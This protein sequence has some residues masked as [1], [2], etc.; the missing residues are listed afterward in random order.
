[1]INPKAQAE[2]IPAHVV[3]LPYMWIIKITNAVVLVEANQEFAI[4]DRNVSWHQRSPREFS[5]ASERRKS[6]LF[7]ILPQLKVKRMGDENGAR[8][9]KDVA[10]DQKPRMLALTRE[11]CR[12]YWLRTA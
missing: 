9:W 8:G 1:M 10:P 11:N 2:K 6:L 3:F 12:E 4:S 5:S 7:S